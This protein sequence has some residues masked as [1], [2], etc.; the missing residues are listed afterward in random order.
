MSGSNL[1]TER[2]S[3]MS[4]PTA[5]C[6]GTTTATATATA[7]ATTL[8]LVDYQGDDSIEILPAEVRVLRVQN[9]SR[10]QDDLLR[11]YNS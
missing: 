1:L 11:C 8:A 2:I 5:R 4:L 9:S 10:A 7:A 6:L 3:H